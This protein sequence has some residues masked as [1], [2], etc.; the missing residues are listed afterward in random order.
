MEQ[1]Q[2]SFKELKQKFELHIKTLFDN[3]VG[4]DCYSSDSAASKTFILYEEIIKGIK[5]IS[6]DF[7]YAATCIIM[8]KNDNSFH[9]SSSC[10]WET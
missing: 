1:K 2:I 5:E 10:L 6:D 9:M 3:F 4:N 7:K 8:S